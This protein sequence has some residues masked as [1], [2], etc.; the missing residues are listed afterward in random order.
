M[1]RP[2]G[3]PASS[4]RLKREDCAALPVRML[5]NLP[6]LPR[7]DPMAETVVFGEVHGVPVRFNLRLVRT[8]RTWLCFCPQCSRRAA[9]LYFPPGSVEPGCR[10]CLRLV[11]ESQY[12][13]T[14]E[15]VHFA[16]AVAPVGP[17]RCCSQSL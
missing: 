1:N 2:R 17:N 10:A 7:S 5:P 16:S 4:K 15:W 3:R 9:V 12:E 13:Y 14:P 8:A 6:I 11:Y